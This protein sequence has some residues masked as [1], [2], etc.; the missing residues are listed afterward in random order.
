VAELK[1]FR[2]RRDFQRGQQEWLTAWRAIE[3]RSQGAVR[4]FVWTPM[5][6][7]NIERELK[8]GTR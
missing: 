7:D 6:W 5:D 8:E 1:S 2:G 3:Q 4:A